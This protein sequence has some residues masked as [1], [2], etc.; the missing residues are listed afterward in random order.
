MRGILIKHSK[1]RKEKHKMH[2]VSLLRGHQEIVWNQI[3][4]SRISNVFKGVVT[5]WQDPT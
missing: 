3:L 4:T 2:G 1:L 5:S